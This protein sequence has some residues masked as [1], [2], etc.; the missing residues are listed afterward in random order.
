MAETPTPE[1]T[2]APLPDYRLPDD[3]AVAPALRGKS[4]A[5]LAAYIE[6]LE[7]AVSGNGGSAAAAPA[8]PSNGNNTYATT[9]QLQ[10]LAEQQ[11][12]LNLDAVRQRHEGVLRRWG[13]EVAEVLSRVPAEQRSLDV[14]ENAV[15]FVKGRHVE[16]I[17]AERSSGGMP[18]GAGSMLRSTGRAPMSYGPSRPEPGVQ[19]AEQWRAKAAAVGITDHQVKEF[20]DANDMTPPEFWSQFG[21]GLVTDAVADVGPGSRKG[22]G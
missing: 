1:P 20:C 10:Q 8:P 18:A 21:S 5:D 15:M 7:R 22:R 17:V 3:P 6:T 16:E 9:S 2:P 13:S 19:A 4:V 14:I 11:A 12:R